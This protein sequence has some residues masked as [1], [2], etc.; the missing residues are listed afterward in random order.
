MVDT[1]QL[2]SV[3]EHW[4]CS[5]LARRGWAAGLTRDDLARTD[6]LAVSTLLP[7]RPTIDMQVKSAT[8]LPTRGRVSWHFGKTASLFDETAREW[9][10]LVVVPETPEP[11]YA[12]LVPRDHVAAATHL[13]RRSLLVEPFGP[14][15]KRDAGQ[16]RGRT[17]EAVFD[18]YRDRWDLLGTPT[19]DVPVLLPQPLLK[20]ID[21]N[22][23]GLPA[24]HPW[25]RQRP[26]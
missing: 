5:E 4:V 12:Y 6:V 21:D 14:P 20:L 26:A 1:Q 18:A 2:K 7:G 9:F 23:V 19:V 25:L 13:Y 22:R 8:K 3:A 15:G 17:A 10:V 16:D 24:D 11:L